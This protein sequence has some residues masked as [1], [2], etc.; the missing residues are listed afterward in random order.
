MILYCK[1]PAEISKLLA[2]Q[3]ET[4]CASDP[5]AATAGQEDLPAPL[6]LLPLIPQSASQLNVQEKKFARLLS[7]A[8]AAAAPE[9]VFPPFINLLI[10]LF[11]PMTRI[12]EI[13]I[14]ELTATARF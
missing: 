12:L 10:I 3:L 5:I 13:F 1:F 4:D 9:W 7:E 2:M 14:A 6:S 8:A 11:L